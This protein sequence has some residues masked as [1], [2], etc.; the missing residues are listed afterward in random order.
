MQSFRPYGPAANVNRQTENLHSALHKTATSHRE[1]QRSN[2]D[3]DTAA[4]SHILLTISG[5]D[6]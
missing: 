6:T 1:F 2:P 5:D 3:L 4:K